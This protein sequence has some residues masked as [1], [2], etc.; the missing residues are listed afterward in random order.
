MAPSEL[1][2]LPM[3]PLLSAETRIVDGVHPTGAEVPRQVSRIKTSG[4][5]LVSFGTRLPASVLK[6]TKRPSPLME[7][8][9]ES[10]SASAPPELTEIRIV[11]GE[12]F[13]GAAG[14]SQGSRRYACTNPFEELGT[15]L[16]AKELNAMYRPSPLM[17]GPERTP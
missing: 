2:P 9:V 1:V 16:V 11:E 4:T 17:T 12:Q 7:F 13:A 3:F 10:P 15:R 5:V 14:P 6:T 8:G